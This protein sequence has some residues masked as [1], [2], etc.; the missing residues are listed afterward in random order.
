MECRLCR[1]TS[2]AQLLQLPLL[3]AKS[4]QESVASPAKKIRMQM[5]VN[6]FKI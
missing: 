3:A 6:Q 4:S 1:T 2:A 5:V